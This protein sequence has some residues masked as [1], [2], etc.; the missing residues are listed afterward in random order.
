[1]SNIPP[2]QQAM[3]E[4]FQQHM[5]AEMT[6]DIEATMATMSDTP[7]VNHIPVMA[8]GVGREGVRQFY[9]NHLVGKFF[10]PDV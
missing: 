3:V 5:A 4:I 7:Y 1:M 9:A 10:P 6:G 8:G 2:V